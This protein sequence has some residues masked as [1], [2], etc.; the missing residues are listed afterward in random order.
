MKSKDI[1]SLREAYDSIYEQAPQEQKTRAQE[2]ED[3]RKSA[4][5]ATLAG[6]SKEAQALMSSRTKNILGP[7]KLRAG[8][9]AQQ[10]VERMKT[11]IDAPKV[12]T[13]SP[14]PTTSPSS[15]PS[16]TPK[17]STSTLPK[18]QQAP[19]PTVPD[20][21][22]QYQMAWDNR[23]NPLARGRI[24]DAWSKMTPEEKQAA[25]DWATKKGLNWKDMQLESNKLNT[26]DTYDQ[27]LE[28]LLGEGFSLEESNKI[29]ASIVNENIWRSVQQRTGIGKPGVRPIQVLKNIGKAGI[30]DI[31]ATTLGTGSTPSPANVAKSTPKITSTPTPVV[32]TVKGSTIRTT[33]RGANV[34]PDPW[35]GSSSIGS[36]VKDIVKGTSS[37]TPQANAPKALGGS[38]TN[39]RGLL[40]TSS[41]A[42]RGGSIV[43]ATP[44][45]AITPAK[46]PG[47]LVKVE[48]TAKPSTA[49][50][51]TAAKSSALVKPSTAAKSSAL[52]K[53]SS[54]AKPSAQTSA[55]SQ[56]F[57]DVQR[58]TRM[59]GG[60]LMGEL[61]KPSAEKPAPKPAWGSKASQKPS[62]KAQTP[63]PSVSAQAPKV[64]T[65]PAAKPAASKPVSGVDK[66]SPKPSQKTKASAKPK[67]MPGLNTFG[68]GNQGFSVP[69]G[70]LGAFAAGIQAYNTADA[71]PKTAPKFPTTAK[72]VKKGETYY[73]PSTKVGPSQRFAQRKKVGPKIVGPKLSVAQDFDRAYK[74]AKEKSGMGSTFTW[75]G[76]T[77]KVS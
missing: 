11:Q 52:T 32:R 57:R 21:S 34:L 10:A 9:E 63:K 59:T 38:T 41:S 39:V 66:I 14:T 67:G 60:G 70:R 37:R 1:K 19:K 17:P 56:Q 54:A 6:P 65:K 13:T 75:R 26:S 77:Y 27:V 29:M 43:K 12:Q 16:P 35:K 48:P 24:K 36:R 5:Q 76:K 42:P 40:P 25:K 73:D 30:T 8:I 49:K 71:T 22:K 72:E 46:K 61:P 62:T 20:R 4:A 47:S 55:R 50:P 58:L 68:V 3:L 45:G 53:P 33:P 2:L 51:S 31:L 18:T 15:S 69:G 44:S 64:E 74:A 28:Y 7:E 23:N